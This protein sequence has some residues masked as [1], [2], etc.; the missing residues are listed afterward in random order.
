MW[1]DSFNQ[2]GNEYFGEYR[3][4]PK[5][6]NV[7]A[8]SFCRRKLYDRFLWADRYHIEH[9]QIQKCL[10][11]SCAY[12][13]ISGKNGIK[14]GKKQCGIEIGFQF[15]EHLIDLKKGSFMMHLKTGKDKNAEK[16]NF[17]L[18]FF[19]KITG[20]L[21]GVICAKFLIYSFKDWKNM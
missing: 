17:F 14:T 15:L 10:S 11:R 13:C 1:N 21:A 3:C 12:F 2:P 9:L 16:T 20:G 5:N 4:D 8:V 7:F 6:C 19:W 18:R